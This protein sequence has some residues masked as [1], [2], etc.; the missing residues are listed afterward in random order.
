MAILRRTRPNPLARGV[1][2]AATALIALGAGSPPASASAASGASLAAVSCPTA[3]WCM[4]VGS[5]TTSGVEHAL[6][7][8]W[9]GTSWRILKAPGAAL[10]G[11]SCTATWF[12]LA[13]GGPTK[14]ER[15]NGTTWREI[16]GPQGAVSPPSCGSRSWCVVINGSITNPPETFAETWNGHR[17][18]TWWE[19]T[20]LCVQNAPGY[21]CSLYDVACGSAAN[22]VTVGTYSAY[23][24][25]N[26]PPASVA[27]GYTW[28]GKT[29]TP[30]NFDDTGP[31]WEDVGEVGPIT[32]TGAFCLAFGA[33]LNELFAGTWNATTQTWARIATPLS[34]AS[35]MSCGTSTS[36]MALGDRFGEYGQ[37]WNGTTWTAARTIR[38]GRDPQLGSVSCHGA[39]C[40]AV[41][42]TSQNGERTLTEIWNG[43]TWKILATPQPRV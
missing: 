11:L 2:L 36:C 19:D 4:A 17:W 27:G 38:E 21:P 43:A 20:D 34:G 23:I 29:W 35:T 10:T 16:P 41:G 33:S 40:L 15:W 42:Y 37:Y 32:C 22:C 24:Y 28:N 9:N 5:Y 14:A 12:C 3:S 1:A 13:T 25:T 26:E 8:V 30:V 31:V 39:T 6:A 18:R 7:Q